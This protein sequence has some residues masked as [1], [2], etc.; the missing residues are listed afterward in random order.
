MASQAVVA[1][2]FPSTPYGRMIYLETVLLI[3]RT[4]ALYNCNKRVLALLI[5][6]FMGGAVQ[7]VVSFTWRYVFSTPQRRLTLHCLVGGV[8]Q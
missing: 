3:L 4:Y 6:M 2:M 1:G 7:S 8:D 5:C